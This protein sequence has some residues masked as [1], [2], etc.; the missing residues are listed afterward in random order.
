MMLSLV[1]NK[2]TSLVGREITTVYEIE[3]RMIEP[4]PHATMRI[5]LMVIMLNKRN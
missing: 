1:Q 5:N 4:Q 3:M 2:D